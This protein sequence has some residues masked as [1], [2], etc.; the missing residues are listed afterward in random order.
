[1]IRIEELRL[2]QRVVAQVAAVEAAAHETYTL[3]ALDRAIS[4]RDGTLEQWHQQ[5]SGSVF[6]PEISTGFAAAF[7]RSDERV[8]LAGDTA[9]AATAERQ[10]CD[11]AWRQSD[12]HCRQ[13]GSLL[14]ESRRYE[15]R[16]RDEK[17]METAADRISLSWRRR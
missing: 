14:A 8:V 7:Q 17:A 2:M 16:A 13:A 3:A 12:A 1:M 15:A 10:A 11:Q 9:T 5:L 4:Q 6:S